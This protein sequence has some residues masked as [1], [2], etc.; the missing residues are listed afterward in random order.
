MVNFCQEKMEKQASNFELNWIKIGI[1]IFNLVKGDRF[2]TNGKVF[3]YVPSTDENKGKGK[4]YRFQGRQ[5]T[6]SAVKY[7]KDVL[8]ADNIK[9]I[10]DE[11]GFQIYEV[12]YAYKVEHEK[13]E[14]LICLQIAM[15]DYGNK[16]WFFKTQELT[17]ERETKENYFLTKS[18]PVTHHSQIPKTE[19]NNV[20]GRYNTH[21]VICKM[22]DYNEME[23]ALF[24][25]VEES[26][27]SKIQ[28]GHDI[29][30]KETENL[31][32]FNELKL[33]QGY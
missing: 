15:D 20:R 1:N 25:A 27:L 33:K 26:Q 2:Q 8:R 23:V 24:K 11:N 6:I 14:N 9:M 18:H 12:Q 7:K 29:I 13:A 22:D 19:L 16:G 17:V 3:L 5:N 28:S 31:K 32:R 10:K 21:H 30:K 4:R